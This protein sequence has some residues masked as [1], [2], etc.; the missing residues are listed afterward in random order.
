MAKN[1]F[2]KIFTPSEANSLIPR[3]E[4][5]IRG[6]QL[7]AEALRKRIRELARRE[8]AVAGE[9]LPELIR[10]YPELRENASRMA[11]AATQVEALGGL[12]KD[13]DHGLVD[14]PCETEGDVVFLCW[15]F[16]EREIVAW[17][18][19][20][21]GFAQRRPLPGANKPYLN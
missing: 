13:I 8:P 20:E 9:P 4:I 18:P 12:L 2:E 17:H 10:R 3:L 16:G 7:E 19:I 21:G 11:E 1:R 5:L 15:Q 14:F 6:L